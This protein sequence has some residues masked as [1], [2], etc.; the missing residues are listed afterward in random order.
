MQTIPSSPL[1]LFSG[2]CQ[3]EASSLARACWK[4]PSCTHRPGVQA[5]LVRGSALPGVLSYPKMSSG[6]SH[7]HSRVEFLSTEHPEVQLSIRDL[8]PPVTKSTG[9]PQPL[10]CLLPTGGLSA[11]SKG[12]RVCGTLFKRCCL[13]NSR[14]TK[15]K[16]KSWWFPHPAKTPLAG[17]HRVKR[18]AWVFGSSQIILRPVNRGGIT[19]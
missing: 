7:G 14:C 9:V 15:D 5:M 19:G 4:E 6:S 8:L 17:G 3:W 16:W 13:H 2:G 10:P 12:E 11:R 1:S 18:C